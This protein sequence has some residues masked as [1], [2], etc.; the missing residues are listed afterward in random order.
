M[1][2]KQKIAGAGL[3]IGLGLIA[4]ASVIGFETMQ[5]RVPPS[6]ARVG[7]QIFPYIIAL[8]MALTGA[9]IAWKS[10]RGGDEV[11]D[12]VEPT[13]WKNVGI[14]LLGLIAHMNLLRPAGFVP[15]GVV[16]FMSVTFAFGSR[17]FGRD[18]MI[19]FFLVLF[20]YIGFT[21]GLGLQL[22]P[23]ILKGLL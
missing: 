6:Y 2:T 8:G 22:P 23:G 7:P 10:Y 15:A 18:A 11:I 3:A 4:I 16:L 19:G 5:M 12:E 1:N 13:D 21:Y 17:R 9:F 14:I 20:A